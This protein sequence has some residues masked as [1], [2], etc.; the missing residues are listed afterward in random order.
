MPAPLSND[1]RRRIYQA[2]QDGESCSESAERFD[3]SSAVVRRLVQRHR[4]TGSLEPRP[5]T[6]GPRRKLAGHDAEIRTLLAEQP[7]L[8]AGEVRR[9]LGVKVCTNTVWRALR[10]LG[11]TSKKKPPRRRTPP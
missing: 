6:G 1:L 10:R 8:T 4:E 9:K 7:D 5:A 11:L 3:V 2:V